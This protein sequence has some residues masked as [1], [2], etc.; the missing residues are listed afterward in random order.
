ML[1]ELIQKA[2]A[3]RLRGYAPYSKYLVGAALLTSDGKIFT[4][5]N[6]ENGVLGL[7]I[8]AERVAITQAVAEGHRKF[9]QIVIAASP[10]AP[11]CGSCRQFMI[12]FGDQIQVVSIDTSTQESKSWTSGELLP[13][14]FKLNRQS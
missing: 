4:G 12:E 3:V 2:T 14:Y 9:E 8:C 6:V 11:P 5:C 13:D 1:E 10:L 7:S